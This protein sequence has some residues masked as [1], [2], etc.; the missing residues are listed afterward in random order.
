[1]ITLSVINVF[2]CVF[3]KLFQS[4]QSTVEGLGVTDF[5]Y[6]SVFAKILLEIS[7][8]KLVIN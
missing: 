2:I 5:L 4:D 1:M 3:K 7:F 8:L 6:E